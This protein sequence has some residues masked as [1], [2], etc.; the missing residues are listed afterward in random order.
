MA[1]QLATLGHLAS[2]LYVAMADQLATLGH[3]ASFLYV[4]IAQHNQ[5]PVFVDFCSM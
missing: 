1:D 5:I 2:F 3:L 4:A